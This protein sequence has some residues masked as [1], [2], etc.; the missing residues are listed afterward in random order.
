MK[1]KSTTTA[2]MAFSA[3]AAV[4][5]Q[6]ALII[7]GILDGPRTGGTPKGI[8][9]YATTAIADL[10]VYTVD[11][12]NNGL[13]FDG[14]TIALSGS[15]AAGEYI[16]IAS[17]TVGFTAY[18]GFAPDFTGSSLNVNGDDVVGLFLNATLVDV[19]GVLGVDGSGQVWD[20]ADGFAY[21]K[22]DTGP[23]ATFI[24][25]DWT[26][27]GID[28]LDIQGTSGV[29]GD[30]SV[31]VPFGTFTAVPEPTAALLGGLGLLALLR[32]RR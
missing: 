11:N 24:P 26:F 19:Y 22:N 4:S 27:S 6:G 29:N 16:Y 13:A 23:S 14:T 8:E 17:E 21:R 2:I 28:A 7:T 5:S 32:R 15:V 31:T 10:S 25:A 12:A 1:I 30:D 3:I 9:L 20:Y 18:F